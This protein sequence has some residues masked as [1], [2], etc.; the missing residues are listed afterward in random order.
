MFLSVFE[1]FKIGIG[2]SSSHTVGPMRAARA[3]AAHGARVALAD[4][5]GAAVSAAAD[6]IAAESGADSLAVE[7]DVTDPDSVAAAADTIES[8]LGTCDVVVANAGILVFKPVLAITH[9]EFARVIDVNLT[10]AFVTAAEFSRRLVATGRTGSVIF[11]S[12]LFGLRGGAGNAAYSASKFGIIGLAESMAAELA[13]HGIRVNCVCP[14]QIDSA[15]LVSLF[16]ERARAAG[17]SAEVERAAFERRIPIGRLGRASEVA[18]T[19]V[20]LAS[21]LSAY[22]TGQKI[23]VDGGWTVG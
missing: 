2:P 9:S 11:T 13:P 18:D 19:F 3:F 6:E 8:T 21:G 4:V 20:Y 16:E 23:V 12:S 7:M 17:T 10:G 15:M 22:V 14:G 5:D 1:L